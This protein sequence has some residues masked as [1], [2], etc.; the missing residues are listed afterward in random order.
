MVLAR[1]NRPG[2][3]SRQTNRF[4]V[5]GKRGNG[6]GVRSTKCEIV[7]PGRLRAAILRPGLR[8]LLAGENKV[9]KGKKEYEVCS[10]YL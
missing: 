2:V 5:K 3:D 8:C 7:V 6:C 9:Q 10:A 1:K 4:G